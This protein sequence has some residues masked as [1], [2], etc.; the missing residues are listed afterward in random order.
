MNQE[1]TDEA[2]LRLYSMGEAAAFESLYQRYRGSLYRYFRR[3]CQDDSASEEMFQDVWMSVIRGSKQ[4]QPDA[5]FKTWLY[6]IAHNR[7]VDYYRR[8]SVTTAVMQ[9]ETVINEDT[10]AHENQRQPEAEEIARQ[11]QRQLLQQI[12][13]LPIDQRDAFLLHEEAG[14]SMEQIGEVMAVGKETAKSRVRYAVDKLRAGM[15]EWL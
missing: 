9:A 12:S 11:R 8:Q 14:L 2:L 10:L 7:L 15:K 5:L 6:R 4:Y 3:Q 13:L 1:Q